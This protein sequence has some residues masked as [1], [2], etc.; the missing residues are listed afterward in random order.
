[1]DEQDNDPTR[2]WVYVVEALRTVEPVASQVGWKSGTG[3][4][5]QQS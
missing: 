5:S 2:L 1:L 4:G 3:V